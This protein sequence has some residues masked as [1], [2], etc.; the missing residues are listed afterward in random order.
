M[1]KVATEL[2]AEER[3]VYLGEKATK[4][5]LKAGQLSDYKVVYFATHGLVA[6]EMKGVNEAALVRSLS[7]SSHNASDA[8]LTVSEIL[9]LKL[10][11]DMV[12]LSAC[13]T[14]AGDVPG[15]EPLSGLARAF[16]YA[17][18]RSL[19]VSHWRVNSDATVELTTCCSTF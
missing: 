8:F 14:A 15:A 18:T 4:E 9:D 19:L 16:L 12:V 10:N 17:G 13:N 6:G 2:G 5:A 1:R 7:P 3:S 11:S